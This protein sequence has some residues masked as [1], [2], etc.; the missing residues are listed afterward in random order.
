MHPAARCIAL[1]MTVLSAAAVYAQPAE[2]AARADPAAS[3]P[4]VSTRDEYVAC[5]DANDAIGARRARFVERERALSQL[6]VRFQAAEAALAA[7]VQKHVPA[8]K[9]EVASYNKAIEQRNADAASFNAATRELQREN[10]ALNAYIVASNARCG[11]ML[12]PDDVVKAVDE[13][14]KAKAA[15]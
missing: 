11:G 7:Q 15:R 13:E 9:G 2:P 1:C 4:R 14:R 6:A 10:A 8:T 5:L 12:V 3:A